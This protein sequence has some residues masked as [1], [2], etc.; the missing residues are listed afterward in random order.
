MP[1]FKFIII[2]NFC[3]EKLFRILLGTLVF[4]QT[5]Q[6]LQHLQHLGLGLVP[7]GGADQQTRSVI[8]FLHD[9]LLLALLSIFSVSA[10]IFVA[11]LN[12]F[13]VSRSCRGVG[14]SIGRRVHSDRFRIVIVQF[15][16]E[17]DQIVASSIHHHALIDERRTVHRVDEQLFGGGQSFAARPTN[18]DANPNLGHDPND[19]ENVFNADKRSV[20]WLRWA[21]PE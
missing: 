1:T 6:T 3:V 15:E 16:L 9:A 19:P 21:R 13:V 2:L 17:H 7:H 11:V 10:S 8:F 14:R 4:V 20:A 5:N 12:A 18:V